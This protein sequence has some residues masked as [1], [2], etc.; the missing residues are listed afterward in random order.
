MNEGKPGGARNVVS[1]TSEHTVQV[2]SVHGDVTIGRA[3]KPSPARRAAVLG[4]PI[5]AAVLALCLF[6][7]PAPDQRPHVA[8]A[9]APQAPAPPPPEKKEVGSSGTGHGDTKISARSDAPEGPS[10]GAQCEGT[11]EN[12]HCEVSSSLTFTPTDPKP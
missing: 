8:P 4:A 7:A 10:S 3:G 2:G 6:D 9:T 5:V 11:G 1:G 12:T